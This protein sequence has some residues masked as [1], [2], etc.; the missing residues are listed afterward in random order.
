MER[1]SGIVVEVDGRASR[2]RF[3]GLETIT[4][5]ARGA[6]RAR[7][8]R[9]AVGDRVLVER[10]GPGEGIIEAVLPRRTRL[11]RG[12]GHGEQVIAANVDQ[13]AI[14]ASV[15]EPSWRPGL[16][17]RLLCA[18][19]K[20]GLEPLVVASKTDLL[21]GFELETAVRRDLDV[22]RRLGLRVVETSTTG[23][24]GFEA[25]RA[26]LRG[27]VTVAAGQSGVGKSSLINAIEPGLVLVTREVSRATRKGRHTTTRVSLLPLSFGGYVLDTPGVRAFSLYE[28]APR[29]LG[30]LFRDVA[31]IAPSCRFRDCL[32][33]D[34]PEC[35]VR[36]A[37]ESGAL[38]GRRY[39]SYRRILASLGSEGDDERD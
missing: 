7:G 11:A 15:R 31:A 27:R 13:L 3:D 30:G 34:E 10:T 28:I 35:A 22:F 2:V 36:Y 16:V 1:L 21:E 5:L 39:D 26:A 32:H 6:I 9:I 19:V 12:R 4:C 14:V 20:G 24:T 25:L 18:A 29:E 38:D 23:N 33:L 8:S 17:D 37:A